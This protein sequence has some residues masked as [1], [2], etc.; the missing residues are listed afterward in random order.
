MAGSGR[1]G[2]FHARQQ[3]G[4][5]VIDAGLAEHP[6][7]AALSELAAG[8]LSLLSRV[9]GHREGPQIQ[10]IHRD[11]AAVGHEVDDAASIAEADGGHGRGGGLQ[12]APT[13]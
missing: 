3:P 8:L 1:D 7:P 13:G 11:A 4:R 6:G 10:V 12:G 9:Q 2:P 5:H